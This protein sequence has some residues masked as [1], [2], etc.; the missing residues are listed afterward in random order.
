MGEGEIEQGMCLG[1]FLSHIFLSMESPHA[2]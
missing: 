2:D 1:M